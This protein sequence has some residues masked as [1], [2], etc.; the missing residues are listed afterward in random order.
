VADA[1]NGGDA[2]RGPSG[3][4]HRSAVVAAVVLAVLLLVLL[5]WPDGWFL[6][7]GF[8]RL[9]VFLLDRGVPQALT[10]EAYAVVANVAVFVPLGWIGVA[11][12]R[13]PPVRVVLA[14][15]A[16]SAGVELVQALPAVARDPS[17]LDVGCNTLGAAI[18]VVGA[19]VVRRR[20][21][22]GGDAAHDQAGVDQ[23][24]D[25]RRDVGGDQLGR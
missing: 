3:R 6:N 13:W 1:G 14:L 23:P 2:G 20:R 21:H 15:T 24:G 25:E 4:R 19:S 16:F 22:H 8:V 12:L 5:L 7:R 10:P 18:G 11:L 9:Y 17:L